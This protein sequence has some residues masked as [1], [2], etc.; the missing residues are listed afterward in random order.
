MPA[1][2][3][4]DDDTAG[5]L[6]DF[7]APW[8]AQLAELARLVVSR[9]GYSADEIMARLMAI[10]ALIEDDEPADTAPDA[11]EAADAALLEAAAA[12]PLRAV[13]RLV[14]L[15][16]PAI[17]ERERDVLRR[18]CE[19]AGLPDRA[20]STLFLD[21]LREA[22]PARRAV[23]IEDRTGYAGA[24]ARRAPV[25]PAAERQELAARLFDD[26]PDPGPE[27]PGIVD[28]LFG[29]V[30]PPAKRIVDRL[31]DA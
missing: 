1:P 4:D 17:Y 29:R 7:Q 5:G 11:P 28:A 16:R 25:M 9:Q 24:F 13:R 18:Q 27:R 15:A 3:M 30:E 8:R 2:E 10:V 14:A 20:I 26:D 31:F 19:D 23:L 22:S 12:V 6:A 21:Q